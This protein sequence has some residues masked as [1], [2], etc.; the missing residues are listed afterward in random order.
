MKMPRNGCCVAGGVAGISG[1]AEAGVFST[2]GSTAERERR[3]S[4][5]SAFGVLNIFSDKETD[6][7]CF[8]KIPHSFEFA[9]ETGKAFRDS[10]EVA[11]N[12]LNAG[13]LAFSENF[14]ERMPFFKRL[15]DKR[16]EMKMQDVKRDV[17]RRIT[18]TAIFQKNLDNCCCFF[19]G[20]DVSFRRECSESLLGLERNRIQIIRSFCCSIHCIHLH[21]A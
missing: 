21:S 10:M 7:F 16:S 20:S 11:A 19:K 18:E 13:V 5:Y 2:I 14:S 15:K 9:L 8:E 6:V 17:L 4:V 3:R 1:V 12:F